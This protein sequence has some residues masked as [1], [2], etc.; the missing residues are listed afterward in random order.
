MPSLEGE[1]RA[2]LLEEPQLQ[3][4]TF[5]RTRAIIVA[6]SVQVLLCGL[7]WTSVGFMTINKII[8]LPD[9]LALRL[10]KNSSETNMLITV[11][12]TVLGTTGSL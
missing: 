8:P 6:M 11:I 10:H 5:P 4:R 2:P 3:R 12:S 1:H 9:G 7:V